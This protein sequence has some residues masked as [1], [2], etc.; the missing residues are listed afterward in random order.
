[1]SSTQAQA[2]TI[3][4]EVRLFAMLRERAGSDRI[5]LSLPGRCDRR[6]RARDASASREPLGELLARLPVRMAVNRDY[7]TGETVLCARRRAG[8]DPAA[9]RRRG[10]S[11]RAIARPRQRGAAL[12]RGALARRRPTHARA[13]SSSSRASRARSQRLDYEAYPRWPRS[14]SRRSCATASRARSLRR[15]RRAPGR[16]VRAGRAERDRRGLRAASRRSV[17]GRARSDRPDQGRGADLEARA[18][19]PAQTRAGCPEASRPR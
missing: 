11:R 10:R 7:A 2:G 4:V 14:A 6:R 15:G 8:A 18:P 13:R 17:R 3:V 1:M 5:E 19:L 12:A 16:R 9:Q